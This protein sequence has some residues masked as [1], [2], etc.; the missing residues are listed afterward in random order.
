MRR[1]F[2][3]AILGLACATPASKETA[4]AATA[5]SP[6]DS[7]AAAGDSAMP[8][9]E[10]APTCTAGTPLSA[11]SVDG[12]VTEAACQ[13]HGTAGG[14]FFGYAAAGGADFDG[15]GVEDF[16]IGALLADPVVGDTVRWDAGQV[17]L[18]SGAELNGDSVVQQ[19][20]LP[21]L[22][23]GE[24]MGAALSF[25][26][27]IDADGDSELWVGA[28]SAIN[29]AGEE[30]G[31]VRLF[32]GGSAETTASPAPA[33]T[34][35]GTANYGRTGSALAGKSDFNGDGLPDLAMSGQLWDRLPDGTEDFPSRGEVRLAEGGTIAGDLADT[36]LPVT[37]LGDGAADQTG[38]ALATADLDGDGYDDLIIGSPYGG[39][40]AGKVSQVNGGPDVFTPNIA[41][42]TA[43]ASQSIVGDE[44]GQAFGWAVAAGDVTG[45]S[46][47]DVV[48]GAP[49]DD[50]PWGAEGA[51]MV[52]DGAT[53]WTDR[54]Y[55]AKRTGEADDHQLGTGLA[56]GK[57]VN[58]DGFGDIVVGAVAAWH[59]LRPKSGRVYLL[60]GGPSLTGE[61]SIAGTPQLHATGTKDYLG[62]AAAWSDVNQDGR[63]DL[64]VASAYTNS[65]AGTDA[66]SAWL[67]FGA[68]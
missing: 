50:S 63:A 12:C 27:D 3:V 9:D 8:P 59:A 53:P 13:W 34:I 49:L 5:S 40:S 46:V 62:R 15:D 31:N 16:A 64:L 52:I 48:I 18:L 11:I 55:I 35:W 42:I 21:G 56:V 45:D 51:V 22:S 43:F 44:A 14:D 36:D 67:F 1:T 47:P 37:L 20:V 30:V 25:A 26:G 60:A 24:Q 57:D 17:V 10:V 4:P 41:S 2:I 66:G 33:V 23:E 68:P 19:R 39:G 38:A 28:R 61:A 29:D 54:T 6:D 65:S 32:L 58:G 7:S